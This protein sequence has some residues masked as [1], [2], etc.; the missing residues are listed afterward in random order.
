VEKI[1]QLYVLPSLANCYFITTSFDLWMSK[2]AYDIFALVIK[3]LRV[4]WQPKHIAIG[5]LKAFDTSRYALAKD[6]TNL[7]S[8]YDLKKNHCLC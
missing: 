8:K 6:L 2:W 3:F 5:L 1:K 7:L 4:L